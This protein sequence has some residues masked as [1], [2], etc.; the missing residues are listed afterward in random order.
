MLPAAPHQLVSARW[1][2]WLALAGLKAAGLIGRLSQDSQ[3]DVDV[4][5]G[6]AAFSGWMLLR[7]QEADRVSARGS[8]QVSRWRGA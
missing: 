1:A 6:W 7:R 8:T 2:S 5:R 4:E 3:E